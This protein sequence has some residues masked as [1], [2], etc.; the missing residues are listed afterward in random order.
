[1]DTLV[2]EPLYRLWCQGHCAQI[3]LARFLV[4][5]ILVKN[6]NRYRICSGQWQIKRLVEFGLTWPIFYL[7]MNN[8]CFHRLQKKSIFITWMLE[9]KNIL[10]DPTCDLHVPQLFPRDKFEWGLCLL[11]RIQYS[12]Y[13]M[14]SK[15]CTLEQWVTWS[16]LKAVPEPSI[17]IRQNGDGYWNR[18][19]FDS[20]FA[21]FTVS[22]SRTFWSI[23][24]PY[25]CHLKMQL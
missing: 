7:C 4:N 3:G 5:F 6:L 13:C 24:T 14:F 17:V 22:L 2:L 11:L 21:D 20:S 25:G 19:L 16:V 8:I 23:L 15:S 18:S 9:H 10:N 12:E 1:M